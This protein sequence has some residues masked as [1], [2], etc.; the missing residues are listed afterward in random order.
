[1][2]G[3][4]AGAGVIIHADQPHIRQ[5]ALQ[6]GVLPFAEDMAGETGE[7]LDAQDFS[8]TQFGP[9]GGFGGDE[10]AVSKGNAQGSLAFGLTLQFREGRESL[11]SG[12]MEKIQHFFLNI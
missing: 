7:G 11:I 2:N 1:M 4:L 5:L 8:V 3:T 12:G 9:G 10:P 6:S